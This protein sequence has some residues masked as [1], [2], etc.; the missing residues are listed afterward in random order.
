VNGPDAHRVFQYLKRESNVA[1][2]H[3]NFNKWLV[4]RHGKVRQHY[5]KKQAPK[6]MEELIKQLL[7]E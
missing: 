6:D 2:V 5:E 4:D 1:K 3:G 7:Q